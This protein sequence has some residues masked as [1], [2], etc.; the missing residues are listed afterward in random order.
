MQS[1]RFV[2]S[3]LGESRWIDS[4][5]SVGSLAGTALFGSELT[6]V[7][8]VGCKLVS[9]NLREARL[10][11]VTFTDCTLDGVD[12]SGATLTDVSFPG[13]SLREVRFDRA[14]M[15]NVDLREARDLSLH[16]A[17]DAL[18]GLVITGLQLL[19][20]APAFAQA[21]GVRVAD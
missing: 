21:L 15:K 13:S 5:I 19:D 11:D 10:R 8:F 12:F 17:P 16:V 7:H 6:R 1:V 20:L 18:S 3:A 4:E 9:V 14:K 2:G